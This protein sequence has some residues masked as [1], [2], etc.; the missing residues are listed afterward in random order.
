MSN[1][2]KEFKKT[3]QN[4]L[5]DHAKNDKLFGI[6]YAKKK[7]NIDE[8]ITY[9]LNTVKNTGCKGFSDS[10]IYGMAIHYYDED[11]VKVGSKVECQ[12]VVNHQIELTEEEKRAARRNAIK[13]LEN[14][15][16]EALKKSR[17]RKESANVPTQQLSL[18]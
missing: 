7:K 3:I 1:G 15:T 14:E 5:E 4:Y 8:C 16:V 13:R 17:R 18:F 2:T 10:E 6:A 12:V 11:D 9:I